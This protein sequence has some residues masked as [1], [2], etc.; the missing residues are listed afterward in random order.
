M[1]VKGKK[2]VLERLG[3]ESEIKTIYRPFQKL[4]SGLKVAQVVKWRPCKSSP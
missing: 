2:L 3:V 4:K 1:K